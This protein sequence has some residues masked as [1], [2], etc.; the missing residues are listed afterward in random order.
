MFPALSVTV[1]V[2]DDAFVKDAVPTSAPLPADTVVLTD[3]CLDESVPLTVTEPVVLVEEGEGDDVAV[4]EGDAV[5]VEVAVGVGEGDVVVD[6]EAPR[7]DSAA[8]AS[9]RPYLTNEPTDTALDSSALTI[10]DAVADG[11]AAA[12][13]PTTPAT[14]GVA[15][16]V[17]QKLPY[18]EL[19]PVV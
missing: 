15:D 3:G 1:N 14:A 16:E 12:S 19:R 7:A 8:V 2:T 11:A 5:A 13:R 17:P 6:D 4:G 18:H 10:C 9:T